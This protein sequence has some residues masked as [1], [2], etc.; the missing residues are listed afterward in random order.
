MKRWI[1]PAWRRSFTLIELLVVIAIIAILAAMLFPGL[2]TALARRNEARCVNNAKGIAT[3]FFMVA[4]DNNRRYPA[5]SGNS[6]IFPAEFTNLCSDL[7]VLSCLSDKGSTSWPSACTPTCY[8]LSLSRASYVYADQ[9]YSVIGLTNIALQS[10][11]Q[12]SSPS[13]KAV[14]AEPCLN[15]ANTKYWHRRLGYG[16]VGYV[17]GHA[18]LVTGVSSIN[19]INAYY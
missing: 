7:K 2:A 1:M 17:D 13:R 9:N 10:I 12:I 16:T 4:Q 8:N 19:E 6:L 5:G 18:G 11:G 14:I 3:I 15:S